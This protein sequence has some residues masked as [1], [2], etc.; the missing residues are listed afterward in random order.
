MKHKPGCTSEPKSQ[1]VN[2]SSGK[3]VEVLT[4]DCGATGIREF[5]PPFKRRVEGR[6]VVEES[7]SQ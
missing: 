4:C 2:N 7:E 3:L 5:V 6:E 1:L